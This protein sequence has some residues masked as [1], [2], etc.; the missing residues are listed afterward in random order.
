MKPIIVD[1]IPSTSF[2]VCLRSVYPNFWDIVRKECYRL[3]GHACECCGVKDVTLECHEVWDYSVK[4]IQKLVE[5]RAL[6]KPCHEGHH[7]G[8]AETQGRLGHALAQIYIVNKLTVDQ[9]QDLYRQA[10]ETWEERSKIEWQLD[11]SYMIDYLGITSLEDTTWIRKSKAFRSVLKPEK[12]KD[13]NPT[14]PSHRS[15]LKN[16]SYQ[17][18]KKTMGVIKTLKTNKTTKNIKEKR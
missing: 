5:F 15:G 10:K 3:A 4:G 17:A 2:G 12:D 14:T 16:G 8:F 18:K 13:P 1:L 7:L 11:V 9:T 6:C